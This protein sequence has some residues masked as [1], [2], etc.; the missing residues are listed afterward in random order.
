[1]LYNA[2]VTS[3]GQVTIPKELREKIGIGAGTFIEIEETETGYVI[4]KKVE[5]DPL[6]KYIG[7]LNNNKSSDDIIKEIRGE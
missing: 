6:K 3:K 2:K 7:F 1:M 5:N 4:R